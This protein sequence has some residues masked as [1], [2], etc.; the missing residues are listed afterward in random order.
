MSLWEH[1]NN[2][3]Q[4][5]KWSIMELSADKKQQSNMTKTVIS[6]NDQEDKITEP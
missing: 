6:K 5:Y 2:V 3:D 4:L 1:V